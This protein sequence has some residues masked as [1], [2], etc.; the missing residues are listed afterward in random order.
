MWG[1]VSEVV[2]AADLDAATDDS[3]ARIAAQAPVAVQVAKQLIDAQPAP[4]LARGPGRRSDRVHRRRS[5]GPGGVPRTT[6]AR[7]RRLLIRCPLVETPA[8]PPGFEALAEEALGFAGAR[9][10]GS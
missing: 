5:R 2:P 6:D 9:S 4:D 8:L 7:I 10:S 1:L 3:R